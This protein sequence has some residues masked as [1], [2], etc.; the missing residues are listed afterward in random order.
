MSFLRRESA[1]A[2]LGAIT[3][4]GILGG[5]LSPLL[6]GRLRDLTGDYRTGLLLC[7]AACLAAACFIGG[8][9]RTPGRAQASPRSGV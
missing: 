5:F 8:L 4:M 7:A 9:G 1:A 3:S 2:G 6:M